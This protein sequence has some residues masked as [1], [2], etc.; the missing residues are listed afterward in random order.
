MRS[1]EHRP[2]TTA[3][4]TT[5]HYLRMGCG[6]LLSMMLLIETLALV[7]ARE[8]TSRTPRPA[9]HSTP[10]RLA[11]FQHSSRWLKARDRSSHTCRAIMQPASLRRDRSCGSDQKSTIARVLPIGFVLDILH[12]AVNARFA[13]RLTRP[14]YLYR[15]QQHQRHQQMT[16]TAWGQQHNRRAQSIFRAIKFMN[17]PP[18]DSFPS[19]H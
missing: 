19:C 7:A 8:N 11:D 13:D 9:G 14:S 6:S 4:A 5:T 16:R 12:D 18:T 3:A 10:A 2:N 1:G 17:R 15:V